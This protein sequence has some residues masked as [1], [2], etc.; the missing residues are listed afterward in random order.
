MTPTPDQPQAREPKEALGR[1]ASGGLAWMS[2]TTAITRAMAMGS[3][4]ILAALLSPSELGVYGAALA[5]AGFVE[6]FRDGGV[7]DLLI[8]S[9]EKYRELSG[10]AFWLMFCINLVVGL[11]LGGVGE[12]MGAAYAQSGFVA[13]RWEFSSLVWVIAL[14][15]PL[16]TPASILTA[17]LRIDLRF[18]QLG[19]MYT[20]SALVRYVGQIAMALMGF[21]AMSI[22][23]PMVAS[24]LIE[25]VVAYAYTR[26]TPWMR[27][28]DTRQWWP[29]FSRSIWVSLGSVANGVTNQG[30]ALPAGLFMA[31]AALGV[32]TFSLQMLTQVEMLVAI[33]LMSVLFPILARLNGNPARQG[34]A[35]IRTIRA[36]M[37]LSAPGCVG[38]A[39]VFPALEALVFGGKW[40]GAAWALTAL[41]AAYPLR[42]IMIGVPVPL[43][44]AQ[45]RFR[46]LFFFWLWNGLALTVAA[47]VGAW[48]LGTP[49]GLAM[50]VG[51]V[52]SVSSVA[53][54]V[55]AVGS[56]GVGAGTAIRAMA[57]SYMIA[58]ALGAALMALD[59]WMSSRG[60][61]PALGQVRVRGH[62]VPLGEALRAVTL[63]A[64]YAGSYAVAVRLWARTH[65]VDTLAVAPRRVGV[66][67]ARALRLEGAPER[68]S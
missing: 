3:W 63:G 5:V 30:Y 2:L 17:R 24:L 45:G 31:S 19:A 29:L 13:T 37:L 42:A 53:S 47:G 57:R 65:L 52:M 23:A 49:S 25:G 22:V 34:Q 48:A 20:A 55:W 11:T 27:R 50:S 58:V 66:L 32:F 12:G 62:G 61:W 8:Q 14:G 16:G 21:G 26:D 4:V 38:A 56:V 36:L 59:G 43:L 54:I 46:A 51:I 33:S 6:R 10:S 41:A 7:R 18:K 68:G 39:V 40:S 60:A 67:M 35:V 44:Q 28:P 15:I 1:V 64:V 9:S